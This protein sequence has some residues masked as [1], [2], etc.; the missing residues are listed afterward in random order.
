MQKLISYASKQVSGMKDVYADLSEATHFGSIA[1]W[2][3][4]AVA[5]AGEEGAPTSWSWSSAPR[6]KNEES[7]L[8]A[9]AQTIELADAMELLLRRFAMTHILQPA[10]ASQSASD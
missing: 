10:R 8:I 5:R 7:P 1:M 4:Y 2:A 3:S 9:C 6:W